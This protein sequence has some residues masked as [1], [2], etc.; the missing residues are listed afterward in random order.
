MILERD[1]VCFRNVGV[2]SGIVGLKQEHC[3]PELV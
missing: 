2:D 3:L 1:Q